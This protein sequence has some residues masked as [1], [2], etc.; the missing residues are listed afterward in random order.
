MVKFPE[1]KSW[2]KL[3]VFCNSRSYGASS[4]DSKFL[5]IR[6]AFFKRNEKLWRSSQNLKEH[7]ARLFIVSDKFTSEPRLDV[8]APVSL[9]PGN[10]TESQMR[11]IH[12]HLRLVLHMKGCSI[13][14]LSS[15][16]FPQSGWERIAIQ[17]S[18]WCLEKWEG[19][20][21]AH[22]HKKQKQSKNWC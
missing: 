3:L 15:L 21:W 9:G 4:S 18:L 7:F 12:H 10:Q 17:S 22:L 2:N 11:T 1:E 6:T 8:L 16:H 20:P 19:S 13:T 14:Q 5:K